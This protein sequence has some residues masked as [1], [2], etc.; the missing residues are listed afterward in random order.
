MLLQELQLLLETRLDLLEVVGLLA[1]LAS[2]LDTLPHLAEL[3]LDPRN[4]VL[5]FL[6]HT[7]ILSTSDRPA[8]LKGDTAWGQVG[9]PDPAFVWAGVQSL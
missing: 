1:P 7:N 6:C 5:S 2:T 9:K 4:G 3:I 8:G